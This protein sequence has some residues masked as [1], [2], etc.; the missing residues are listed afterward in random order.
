ME[1]SDARRIKEK[2]N[3]KVLNKQNVVATG[4]GYKNNDPKQGIALIT[5]VTKKKPMGFG[6]GKISRFQAVSKSYNGLQTDVIESGEFKAFQFDPTQKLRPCP[7]GIS[8]GHKG[9]TAGTLGAWLNY[10]GHKVILSNNHV[11]ANSN[12]AEIGDEILQPGS[13]DGGAMPDDMIARLEKF[14]P[15]EF[16][17]GISN[18]PIASHVVSL[19]NWIG[20]KIGSNTELQAIV[21]PTA[22]TNLVDAAIA[23]PTNIQNVMEEYWDGTKATGFNEIGLGDYIKKYGRTTGFTE[24]SVTQTDVTVTVNYGS[25]GMA[26]FTN[27]LM[28][29]PMSAGGDSGSTILNHNDEIV[30]LLFAGSNTS[31]IFS[32]I[33][34]VIDALG[35]SM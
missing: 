26:T 9:V 13:Y 8:I 18:C 32:P 25:A 3:K 12:D 23:Q 33:Q 16:G 21:K 11:I 15:I 6:R 1:Y 24:D 20:G 22:T 19:L 31:T 5:S 17:G 28:A 2:I 30:G 27:Q 14:I 34:L 4:L 7:Q 10:M 35:I 29:G